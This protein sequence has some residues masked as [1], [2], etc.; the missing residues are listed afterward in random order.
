[1]RENPYTRWLKTDFDKSKAVIA[2]DPLTGIHEQVAI[3]VYQRM[4]I[5]PKPSLYL[6]LEQLQVVDYRAHRSGAFPP[7]TP[8]PIGLR[9]THRGYAP[10]VKSRQ[11][12]L[13]R[14][15]KLTWA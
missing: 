10:W 13:T 5:G 6:D 2:E 9:A 15:M 7:A 3:R 12:A 1:V 14:A 8:S 4:G 11:V